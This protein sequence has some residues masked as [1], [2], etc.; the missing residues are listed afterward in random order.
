MGHVAETAR[1]DSHSF[2]S[3]EA[4]L[5]DDGLAVESTI[6]DFSVVK[7]SAVISSSRIQENALVYGNSKVIYSGVAGHGQVYGKA[8][9]REGS[10]VDKDGRVHGNARLSNSH[11]TDQAEVYGNADLRNVVVKGTSHVFGDAAINLGHAKLIVLEGNCK[12]G[13]KVKFT[14]KNTL[15]DFVKKYGENN[16]RLQGE[17]IILTDVWDLGGA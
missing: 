4:R 17:A 14:E 7:G 2:I 9:V 13:G 10:T 1:C 11:I 8:R 12:L 6:A 15:A 5:E 16:V 3:G